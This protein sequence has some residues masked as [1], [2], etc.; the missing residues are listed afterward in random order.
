MLSDK[1]M[2]EFAHFLLPSSI[3]CCE[4][5]IDYKDNSIY[6][7]HKLFMSSFNGLLIIM[8]RTIRKILHRVIQMNF[9][10]YWIQLET[11]IAITSYTCFILHFVN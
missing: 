11:N 5:A 10:L 6:D 2:N 4:I 7:Y 8:D 1:R 3:D 9:D